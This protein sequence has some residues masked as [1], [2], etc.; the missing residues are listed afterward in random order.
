M[1]FQLLLCSF[2]LNIP[3]FLS[4]F[5][6][7][8][9]PA[10]SRSLLRFLPALACNHHAR[11]VQLLALLNRRGLPSHTAQV[12]GCED[13][14]CQRLHRPVK[15]SSEAGYGDNQSHQCSRTR[16]ALVC[17]LVDVGKIWLTARA[18][19]RRPWNAL[20]RAHT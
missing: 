16:M 11:W 9:F 3:N 6:S 12:S 2:A 10:L 5:L 17:Q 7:C 14:P 15:I 1:W 20:D 4:V 13:K 18:P 19:Q 8:F